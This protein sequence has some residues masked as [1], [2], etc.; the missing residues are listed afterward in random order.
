MVAAKVE[1]FRHDILGYFSDTVY[2]VDNNW[3][4]GDTGY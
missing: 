3:L 2:K 1:N 4:L